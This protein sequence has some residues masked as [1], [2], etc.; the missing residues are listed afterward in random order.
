MLSF[1]TPASSEPPSRRPPVDAPSA[2]RSLGR[3]RRTLLKL[4]ERD[5]RVQVALSHGGVTASRAEVVDLLDELNEGGMR[6]EHGTLVAT[7]L[8]V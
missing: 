1:D 8:M 7:Y 4:A 6:R 3:R 2:P 5:G